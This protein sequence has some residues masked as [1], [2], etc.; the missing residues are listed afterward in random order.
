MLPQCYFIILKPKNA[1][2]ITRTDVYNKYIDLFTRTL[3]HTHILACTHAHTHTD[4]YTHT[5]T[6]QIMIYYITD[7]PYMTINI[8][9]WYNTHTHTQSLELGDIIVYRDI[10]VSR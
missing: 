1:P 5:I 3:A 4:A 6:L 10:E 7:V 8:V 2:N 9:T